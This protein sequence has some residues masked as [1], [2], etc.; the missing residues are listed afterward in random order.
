MVP[1]RTYGE[2][3]MRG[4]KTVSITMRPYLY[5]F[6]ARSLTA[7]WHAWGCRGAYTRFIKDRPPMARIAHALHVRVVGTRVDLAR[8]SPEILPRCAHGLRAIQDLLHAEG[9]VPIF[10]GSATLCC[11]R[12]DAQNFTDCLFTFTSFHSR[13]PS[14][15]ATFPWPRRRSRHGGRCSSQLGPC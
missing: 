11:R 6:R 2:G 7:R 5:Q 1:V 12:T 8:V 13:A 3:K 4:A 9:V 10:C 15:Q 14:T